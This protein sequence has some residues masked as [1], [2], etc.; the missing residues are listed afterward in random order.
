M[1]LCRLTATRDMSVGE[2][3]PGSDERDAAF[4]TEALPHMD[5]LYRMAVRLVF[6][7]TKA[8]DAVQDTY[9]L[10]WKSFHRYERNTNCKAWLFQILF[11]VVRKE[12]R[13]WMKWLVGTEEDVADQD[14]I[15]PEPVPT[16]LT[17]SDIL[18]ALDQVPEDFRKVLLL[19]DVEEFSYKEVGT[20][21]GIPVGTV[22]SRL[23]RGRKLLRAQLQPTPGLVRVGLDEWPPG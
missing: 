19:V 14:L 10:A 5:D 12:R 8:A 11:N 9:L 21:L 3:C 16:T 4:E 6:D 13:A 17:D 1:Q 20:I 18:A 7:P 2:H 23:S 15:A 22:M